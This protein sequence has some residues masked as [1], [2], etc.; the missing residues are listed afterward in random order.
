MSTSQIAAQAAMMQQNQQHQHQH[1]YQHHHYHPH[2]HQY[3]QQQAQQQNPH[4]RKRSQ[5]IPKPEETSSTSSSRGSRT[6]LAGTFNTTLGSRD[7]PAQQYANGLLGPAAATTAAAAAYPRGPSPQ[8]PHN[9]LDQRKQEKGRRKLFSKP[10]AIT[11]SKETDLDPKGK[12]LPS[13]NKISQAISN[14]FFRSAH[15]PANAAD[16]ASSSTLTLVPTTSSTLTSNTTLTKPITGPSD[17][18]PSKHHFLSRP[19]RAKDSNAVDHHALNLSS[20]HSNSRPVD[21]SAPQSMYDFTPTSP[22]ITSNSFAKSMSGFDLRHGG[23]ALREKRREDK[24]SAA[25]A[26]A[27]SRHDTMDE[28][29]PPPSVSDWPGAGGY[30]AERGGPHHMTRGSGGSHGSGPGTPIPEL[31]GFGIPNLTADDSWPLLETKVHHLFEG[32]RLQLPIEDLNR[33]VSAHISRAISMQDSTALLDDLTELL[34][35]GFR[36]LSARIHESMVLIA[37]KEM[38]DFVF[39]ILVPT[40]QA[41]FLPLDLEFKGCG[42]LMNKAQAEAFWTSASLPDALLSKSIRASENPFQPGL[43][44]LLDI[45]I[46]VLIYFRDEILLSRYEILRSHFERL[47]FD[48][49]NAFTAYEPATHSPNTASPRGAFASSD[50][51]PPPARGA[52][53]DPG[54]STF[55]SQGSTL[56]DD[57]SQGNRSRTISNVSSVG[58]YS[59]PESEEIL[60]ANQHV[61]HTRNYSAGN[62]AAA[63]A[64]AAGLISPGATLRFVNAARA[65]TH[66]DASVT[67]EADGRVVAEMVS[68]VL[69]CLSVI[70]GVQTGDE[71]Q[72]RIE[73]LREM[74]RS[75]WLGRGRTGR[76]RKGFVGPRRKGPVVG[77]GAVPGRRRSAVMLAS[78]RE[79]SVGA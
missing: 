58:F 18:K 33:L 52:T 23:R 60:T 9:S 73:E 61:R 29:R 13:P 10:K 26:A 49:F 22:G 53:F 11:L 72:K 43:D 12:A 3:Q 62:A 77:V 57:A 20:I 31:T 46:I 7:G 64:A 63:A 56:L 74:V 78:H 37:I 25:A 16:S 41:I 8:P 32:E 66:S 65:R 42:Y 4:L 21:P 5:T 39:G 75:N 2:H 50:L 69:Q 79:V 30:G 15:V 59:N 71:A 76:N 28:L 17:D 44:E 55:D 14:P 1:Q 35:T 45:R 19:R 67:N 27:L 24:A 54:S 70:A 38:W 48:S 47:S 6:P 34:S 36:S 51:Q 68:R 40:L